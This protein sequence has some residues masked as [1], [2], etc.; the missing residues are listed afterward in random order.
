MAAHAAKVLNAKLAVARRDMV[1]EYNMYL[2]IIK[3]YTV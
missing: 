2:A 1:N 3:K